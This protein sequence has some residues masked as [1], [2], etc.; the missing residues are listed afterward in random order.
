MQGFDRRRPTRWQLPLLVLSLLAVAALFLPRPGWGS[1]GERRVA[2]ASVPSVPFNGP[3]AG[4]S[5]VAH[6]VA[7]GFQPRGWS[8]LA[9]VG[10]SG[11]ANIVPGRMLAGL[12]APWQAGRVTVGDA[13]W[14]TRARHF[15]APSQRRN[16]HAFQQRLMP[17]LVPSTT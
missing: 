6:A 1:N 14:C 13:V 2:G 11:R 4:G 10:P 16:G 3:C 8:L 17:T 12:D 15:S 7:G 9:L 5:G